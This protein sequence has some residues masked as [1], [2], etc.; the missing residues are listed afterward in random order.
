MRKLLVFFIFVSCQFQSPETNAQIEVWDQSRINQIL[1]PPTP[2][3]INTI[4]ASWQAADYN[5]SASE[6]VESGEM[7]YN[8]QEFNVSIYKHTIDKEDHFTAI[9]VPKEA[10][11]KSLPILLE[12]RGVRYDYPPRN[13]SKGSFVMSLLEEMTGE[14]IIVEPCLRGHELQ[15]IK[16]M[17]HAGGDRRDSYDGAAKDAAMALTVAISN[18]PAWDEKHVFSFGLS[19]GGGVALLHGQRDKRVTGVI[20]M[21]APTDWLQLMSRPGEHWERR[22]YE[23]AKNYDGAANDRSVQFYEWFLQGRH[24]LSNPEIRQRLIASSPLYFAEHL[25]PTQVHQGTGD[26][27]IPSVNAAALSDRFLGLGLNTAQYQVIFHEGAGH[28]LRDSNA[29]EQSREFLKKLMGQ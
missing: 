15:A 19:R 7:T 2:N 14:F 9:Y 12:I 25:P 11:S 21:S 16:Q 28:L 18:V 5:I 29:A 24:D 17:H 13:I 27:A 1:L 3:E 4:V 23:A 8:Q 10:R 6:L 22:I 20:A 26:S